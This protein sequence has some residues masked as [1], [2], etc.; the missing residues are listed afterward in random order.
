MKELS[1]RLCFR[2]SCGSGVFEINQRYPESRSVPTRD[3]LVV[4][5]ANEKKGKT[6]RIS[7]IVFPLILGMW[8]W[9]STAA[10]AR[11]GSRADGFRIQKKI[12]HCSNTFCF[13]FLR[14]REGTL[15]VCADHVYRR[16]VVILWVWE[17]FMEQ[18]CFA[19]KTTKDGSAAT[20][21][22]W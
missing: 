8:L 4:P 7:L 12:L 10:D 3:L 6:K 16:M 18:F 14:T 1:L 20:V 17:V 13:D 9:V 5:L 2:M 15:S 11:I 21:A 22:F 19:Q